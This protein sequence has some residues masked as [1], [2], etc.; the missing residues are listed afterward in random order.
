L[1]SE[2]ATESNP[3]PLSLARPVSTPIYSKWLEAKATVATPIR[4]AGENATPLL[5]VLA[6]SGEV[7][8]AV[9]VVKVAIASR[10]E[11][12]K[13]E[14]GVGLETVHAEPTVRIRKSSCHRAC[15]TKSLLAV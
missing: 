1:K 11:T 10:L 5:V 6:T 9:E 14:S 8:V 15:V 4:E 3:Q 13:A 7:V 12:V 2:K